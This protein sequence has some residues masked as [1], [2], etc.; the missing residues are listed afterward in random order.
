MKKL[1]LVLALL[2]CF[3]PSAHSSKVIAPG[4][5][6]IT[7]D[8]VGTVDEITNISS[9]DTVDAVTEITNIVDVTSFLIE[10][11][12]GNVAGHTVMNKFGANPDIDILTAPED[13]WDGGGIYSFFPATAQSMEMESTDVD[14]VGTVVASG[15][16][17]GGSLF[18]LEDTG[19]TF[20]ATVTV[21]DFL[22]ND[23]N[24]QFSII[25]AVTD[26]ILTCQPMSN[27]S[28]IDFTQ[29]ANSA[30][31]TYRVVNAGDTG[32]AVVGVYGLDSNY[33][34]QN[35]SVVS[36]GLTP[37]NLTH[38]YIRIYRMAVLTAGSSGSAEGNIDCQIQ[39]G[40]TLAARIITDNNQTLMAIFTI[41]NGHTGYFLQGYVGVTKTGNPA[42]TN[43]ARFTWRAKPSGGVF[44]TKGIIEVIS[45]GNSFW[46][47]TYQGA[48]GIPPLTD[49][50]IRCENV[51]HDATGVVG[52]FDLLL[53]D[54]GA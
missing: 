15:T 7:V 49:V 24:D 19:A 10:V 11:A 31:D 23:T 22:A 39:V 36:D 47:Y 42:A 26:T 48:P 27:G 44:N 32:A 17:T 41:P 46:Q 51:S 28:S 37:V 40:G 52:G 3:A 21:G 54:I 29:T 12:K 8:T 38:D 25:S 33:D 5:G 9:V 34:P 30:G 14:D 4:I 1:L 43:T 45:S 13:V 16:A 20:T 2:L 6:D 35:E 18:T 50:I 53:V